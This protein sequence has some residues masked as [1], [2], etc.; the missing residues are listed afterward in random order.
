MQLYIKRLLVLFCVATLAACSSNRVLLDASSTQPITTASLSQLDVGSRLVV[1]LFN[2]SEQ[3]KGKLLGVDGDGLK[4]EGPQRQNGSVSA[5]I[6][7][8]LK[9]IQ[10]LEQRHFSWVKNSFLLSG[11]LLVMAAAS[12]KNS[13]DK[14][15]LGCSVPCMG[16]P[17]SSAPS[18]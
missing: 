10:R 1:T 3:L 13:V 16:P 15:G 9:D 2:E 5:D 12:V 6:T 4:L 7:I 17:S 8:A 14:I 18:Q 11:I